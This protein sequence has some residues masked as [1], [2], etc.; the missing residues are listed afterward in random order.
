MATINI[1]G[2]GQVE[3]P[4]NQTWATEETQKKIEYLLLQNSKKSTKEKFKNEFGSKNQPGTFGHGLDQSAK[5][6]GALVEESRAYRA[7][8][9][10]NTRGLIEFGKGLLGSN[11]T[12]ST[13]NPLIEKTS[14]VMSELAAGIPVLGGVLGAAIGAVSEV[15]MALN[16][17]LSAQIVQYDTFARAGMSASRSLIDLQSQALQNRISLETLA[18]VTTTSAEGII[19]LGGNFDAGVQKF[20]KTQSYLQEMDGNMLEKLGFT[21]DQQ[22]AFLSE[23]IDNNRNNLLLQRMDQDQLNKAVGDTAKNMR[24]L[25]EFTGADVQAQREAAM[26]NAADIAFQ[27]RLAELPT[28]TANNIRMFVDQL[29][30]IDPSGVLTQ[31]FKEQF[32][33]FGGIVTSQSGIL[34]GQLSNVGVSLEDFASKIEQGEDPKTVLADFIQSSAKIMTDGNTTFLAQLSLVEGASGELVTVSQGL[35]SSLARFAGKDVEEE[36]KQATENVEN[37]SENIDEFN[38]AMVEGR[39]ELQKVLGNL[40]SA[41]L[42]EGEGLLEWQANNV[43]GIAGALEQILDTDA[44]IMEISAGIVN[45]ITESAL[46]VGTDDIGSGSYNILRNLQ[47][48]FLSPFGGNQTYDKLIGINQKQFGGNLFPG[49]TSLVGEAGP[50]LI[51]M[52]SSMGEVLNNSTTTDIMS[53]AAGIVEAMKTDMSAGGGN[54]S[55]TIQ[56]MQESAPMLQSSMSQLGNDMQQRTVDLLSGI[57]KDQS[58]VK[59]LLGR[60]LPKAMSGNGYF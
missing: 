5:S 40:S 12:F 36:L 6:F 26:R 60:I 39:Q 15:R 28:D 7:E 43:G 56:K 35:V 32:S 59:K 50:E 29:A 33:T 2:I 47:N 21:V 25:A 45:L 53:A 18:G 8:V 38:L 4:D 57:A 37:V 46:G 48:F 52:G 9:K 31:A 10:S 30:A 34:Q 1:D 49:M 11:Q 17:V 3:I 51:K 24:I 44:G 58:D 16:D 19:A 13:L 27:A 41:I 23:F 55:N 42:K 20:L 22:A 14:G 54:L